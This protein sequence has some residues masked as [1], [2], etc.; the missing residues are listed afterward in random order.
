MVMTEL[1][2]PFS[3]PMIVVFRSHAPAPGATGIDHA[4]RPHGLDL[5]PNQLSAPLAS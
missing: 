5:G 3:A 2:W 1:L 4:H